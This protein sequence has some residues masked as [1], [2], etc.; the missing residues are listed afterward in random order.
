MKSQKT[1]RALLRML[2][3]LALA[4]GAGAS[5]QATNNAQVIEQLRRTLAEQQKHPNVVIRPGDPPLTNAP[6]PR[7]RPASP[8]DTPAHRDLERQYLDGK[9]TAR[10]YRKA[11]EELNRR[12]PPAPV[13]APATAAAP[14]TVVPATSPKG[15]EMKIV[16]P[17]PGTITVPVTAAPPVDQTARQKKISEVE[18][19]LDELMRA[20]A[21][22]EQ[23]RATN[24]PAAPPRTKRER[25]DALLRQYIE[26]TVPEADY[27]AR[28]EK[29][30]A[31]PD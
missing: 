9:L 10:Q 28:R 26:G 30:L 13:A 31:E 29:I 21:A 4:T 25:L 27:K 1:T 14:R 11:L 8:Y 20:K 24:A 19:K 17:P 22:R 5:G 6:T 18:T 7:T 15:T 3:C 16:T 12:P 2:A 23:A